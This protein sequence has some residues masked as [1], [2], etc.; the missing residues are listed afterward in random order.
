MKFVVED[1]AVA[2][3]DMRTAVYEGVQLPEELMRV[4]QTSR[5]LD[6]KFGAPIYG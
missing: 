5:W 6:D 1:M 4:I 3:E 2:A